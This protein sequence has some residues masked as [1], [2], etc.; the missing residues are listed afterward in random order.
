MEFDEQEVRPGSSHDFSCQGKTTS[1]DIRIALGTKLIHVDVSIVRP[2]PLTYVSLSLQALVPQ[3]KQRSRRTCSTS[4]V[5]IR[6]H[7]SF[8]PFIIET[9]GG[10]GSAARKLVH[11]LAN[12][13]TAASELW[14]VRDMRQKI[15]QGVFEELTLGTSG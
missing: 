9:Y 12:H 4:N 10:F 3:G 11:K 8:V 15:L 5:P 14:S 7:A 2:L 1:T 13:A 6:D